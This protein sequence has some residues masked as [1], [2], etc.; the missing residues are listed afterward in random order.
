MEIVLKMTNPTYI[1]KNITFYCPFLNHYHYHSVSP[2]F[3][4]ITELAPTPIQSIS[5]NVR[6][7]DVCC[8][9]VCPLAV[10]FYWSG[11]ETY[12]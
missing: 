6:L 7:C 4:I 3:Y 1:F 8:G 11:L 2:C 5:Y 9:C 12:S 10:P